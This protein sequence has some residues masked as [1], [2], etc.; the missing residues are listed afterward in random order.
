MDYNIL[1]EKKK[2]SKLALDSK[3]LFSLLFLKKGKKNESSEASQSTMA[4]I[5]LINSTNLNKKKVAAA[6]NTSGNN[7][8]KA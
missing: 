4:A 2:I 6:Q 1:S 3:A 7:S 8:S 5:N